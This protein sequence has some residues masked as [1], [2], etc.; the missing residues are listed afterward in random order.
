L[1]LADVNVGVPTMFQ[2]LLDPV[3]PSP[4]GSVGVTNADAIDTDGVSGIVVASF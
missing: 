1:L 4:G 2:V 3:N